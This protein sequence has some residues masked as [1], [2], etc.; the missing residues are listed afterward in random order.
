MVAIVYVPFYQAVKAM[1]RAGVSAGAVA[2]FLAACDE[3]KGVPLQ[4]LDEFI[5]GETPQVSAFLT[6]EE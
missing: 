5:H 1:A 6:D 2:D 3:R 4:D